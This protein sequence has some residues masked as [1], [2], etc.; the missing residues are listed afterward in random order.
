M[1]RLVIEDVR[2][3]MVSGPRFKLSSVKWNKQ[4][5]RFGEVDWSSLKP[6]ARRG[7]KTT[8]S[9]T[10]IDPGTNP[11]CALP[12]LSLTAPPAPL[13]HAY[14]FLLFS[15]LTPMCGRKLQKILGTALWIHGPPFAHN[16]SRSITAWFRRPIFNRTK[17]TSLGPASLY[18]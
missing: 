4:K 3:E 16:L 10:R 9:K 2:N 5:G 8:A 13:S 15:T 18:F 6:Q 1:G 17:P 11:S 12:K 7:R 14:M